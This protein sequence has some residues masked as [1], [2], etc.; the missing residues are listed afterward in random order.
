MKARV[1]AGIW[2]GAALAVTALVPLRAAFRFD[3]TGGGCFPGPWSKPRFSHPRVQYAPNWGPG[4]GGAAGLNPNAVV[5]RGYSASPADQPPTSSEIPGILSQQQ[6]GSPID[7]G[8]QAVTGGQMGLGGNQSQIQSLEAQLNSIVAQLQAILAQEYAYLAKEQQDVAACTCNQYGCNSACYDAQTQENNALAAEQRALQI[9]AGA[10]PIAAQLQALGVNADPTTGAVSGGGGGGGA[11]PA[12]LPPGMT[13]D[14]VAQ[15]FGFTFPDGSSAGA[16]VGLAMRQ[17]MALAGE[18]EQGG[19]G[20]DIWDNASRAFNLAGMM[21]DFYGDEM[22][23]LASQ[24]E[25][26]AQAANQGDDSAQARLDYDQSCYDEYAQK[27]KQAQQKQDQEAEVLARQ[28]LDGSDA[29]PLSSLNAKVDLNEVGEKEQ[30]GASLGLQAPP[31]PSGPPAIQAGAQEQDQAESGQPGL[32]D[33]VKE[34]V[35]DQAGD[36]LKE[37]AEDVAGDLIGKDR[38][39]NI[40]AIF[41]TEQDAAQSIPLIGQAAQ[42]NAD[43]ASRGYDELQNSLNQYNQTMGQRSRDDFK[44]ALGAGEGGGE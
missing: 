32:W 28:A 39:E 23:R 2:L 21:A 10:Y 13:M 14:A 29:V 41:S 3:R 31:P 35:I 43:P 16:G 1:K 44:T 38:V 18:A 33:K 5:S 26:A 34:G 36:K 15:K 27:Y 12:G 9:A 4:R 25:A 19:Q 30:Q 11:S 22:D 37:A 6:A 40:K 20:D 7:I 24:G 8:A 42:C 17:L